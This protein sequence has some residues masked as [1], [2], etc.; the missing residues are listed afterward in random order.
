M[1]RICPDC[2]KPLEDNNSYFCLS[3]GN[4]LEESLIKTDDSFKTKIIEFV[5][6]DPKKKPKKKKEKKI[7]V[8][9]KNLNRQLM[10]GFVTVLT[11]GLLA[12]GV[13]F[14][15]RQDFTKKDK[16]EEVQI[17]QT[18]PKVEKPNSI[19]LDFPQSNI[20][21]ANEN[22]I[23]YIPY[24]TDFYIIGS[25]VL[26]FH[27]RYFGTD[28][29]SEILPA[30]TPY[31]EGRFITMGNKEGSDWVITSVIYLVD[32]K[33]VDMT[34]GDIEVEG[35]YIKKVDDVLV[36]T[37]KE[38][39]IQ[40]VTDSSK[41][42]ARNIAQNPKTRTDGVQVPKDGQLIFV[43]INS[44]INVLEEMVSLFQPESGALELLRGIIEQKSTKFVIRNNRE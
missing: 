42:F 44:E 15:T 29:P 7:K 23:K 40:E 1:K 25:D 12:V 41:G 24:E 20:N 6:E 33:V 39:M 36:V 4:K 10:I 31:V 8:K 30:I 5:I 34:F 27:V 13:I 26:D 35:K 21:L 17:Q 18:Q 3:C 2:N 16:P 28:T 19:D 9:N 22:I 14:L 32:K 38:E 37:D 11:I 43:D